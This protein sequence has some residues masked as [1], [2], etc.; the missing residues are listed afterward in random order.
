MYLVHGFMCSKVI[1]IMFWRWISCLKKKLNKHRL[2]VNKKAKKE[3]KIFQWSTFGGD[4]CIYYSGLDLIYVCD[5]VGDFFFSFFQIVIQQQQQTTVA[6]IS[7]ISPFAIQ[8]VVERISQ[9][10]IGRIFVSKIG[11]FFFTS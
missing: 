9:C 3:L 4:I 1:L 6:I 5:D 8:N 11:D 10:M 2:I 7:F